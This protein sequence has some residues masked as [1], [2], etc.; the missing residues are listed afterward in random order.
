MNQSRFN[1]IDWK[2]SY[3]NLT[4]NLTFAYLS[5]CAHDI[6]SLSDTST[7]L[8]SSWYEHDIW[9]LVNRYVKKILKNKSNIFVIKY[10]RNCA[11][12]NSRH[13][14]CCIITRN[15]CYNLTRR[16]LTMKPGYFI[17]RDTMKLM[18]SFKCTLTNLWSFWWQKVSQ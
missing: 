2:V 16:T 6:E 13:T 10:W 8:S 11:C 12:S 1:I 4:I 3:F 17:H 14:V 18:L 7:T 15:F 5:W 9:K